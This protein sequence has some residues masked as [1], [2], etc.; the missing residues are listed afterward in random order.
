MAV[1]ANLRDYHFSDEVGDIRGSEIRGI[2]Q[3]KLGEI[4]DV[5]FDSN[6]GELRYLVVDT[7][8]WLRSK[9]F[10]VP[11]RQVRVVEDKDDRDRYYIPLNK[12]QIESFPPYDE[13]LLEREQDWDDYER[14]YEASWT[15]GPV[16]HEEDST[17]II[18]PPSDQIP[19]TGQGMRPSQSRAEDLTPRRISQDM[20]RFGAMS[21]SETDA[22]GD[23]IRE[24]STKQDFTGDRSVEPGS[25]PR[26]FDRTPG[27]R[28]L[29]SGRLPM[30][31]NFSEFQERL[32]RN[33]EAI[34]QHCRNRRRAA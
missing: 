6:S 12:D 16:L 3:E 19:S 4:D 9:R 18:T 2:D 25:E 34:V 23:V 15:E 32:R 30:S 22:V 11:A 5:I 31:R 21:S 17:R 27:E 24:P 13:K 29:D 10:I 8:G 7:G 33:R 26:D 14:R 28:S 1:Y 20:P